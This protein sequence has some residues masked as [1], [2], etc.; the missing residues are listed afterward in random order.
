[1]VRPA[2][3]QVRFELR[4]TGA[5]RCDR[6]LAVLQLRLS[7]LE[8]PGQL[9]MPANVSGN[10]RLGLFGTCGQLRHPLRVG[11]AVSVAHRLLDQHV[12]R[13]GPPLGSF[14]QQARSLREGRCVHLLGHPEPEGVVV[15]CLADP[16]EGWLGKV[17][18]S[19]HG[20]QD[21][22]GFCGE[23]VACVGP[24]HRERHL[25]SVAD[26]FQTCVDGVSPLLVREA[27]GPRCR[28][29]RP[30]LRVRPPRSR[31]RTT[32]N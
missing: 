14:Q 26:G 21:P 20:S 19:E 10:S 7:L 28:S 11:L 29:P 1:M 32:G 24:C 15:E 22:R 6:P 2:T 25:E 12:Q 27:S 3:L 9:R 5:Q 18:E 23:W 4:D 31:C 8:T 30:Q 16:L 13:V 17:R